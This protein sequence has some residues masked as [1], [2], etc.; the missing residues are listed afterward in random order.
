MPLN[1]LPIISPS[2]RVSKAPTG[3]QPE[4]TKDHKKQLRLSCSLELICSKKWHATGWL[5]VREAI[6]NAAR[7]SAPRCC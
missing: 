3:S 2:V 7:L 1:V 5:E 6:A 4:V